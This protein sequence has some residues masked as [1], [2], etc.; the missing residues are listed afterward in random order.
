M[1]VIVAIDEYKL[2][3]GKVHSIIDGEYTCILTAKVED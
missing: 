1:W 3:Q 2:A